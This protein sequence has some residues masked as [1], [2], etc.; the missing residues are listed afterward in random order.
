MIGH[1]TAGS[2]RVEA[3]GATRPHLLWHLLV[4]MRHI[5]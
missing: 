1:C 4:L 5:H 3:T 2:R